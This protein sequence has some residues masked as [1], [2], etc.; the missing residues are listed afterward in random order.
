MPQWS[1]KLGRMTHTAS[2]IRVIERR[3]FRCNGAS[4]RPKPSLDTAHSQNAAKGQTQQR[5]ESI[6]P[7]ASRLNFGAE[8]RT[9]TSTPL[10]VR[11]PEPRA[12]AN[13][14]ISA[15]SKPRYA[16]ATREALVFQSAH[17]L[18]MPG[19]AV[20]LANPFRGTPRLKHQNAALC[21][22]PRI[23]FRVSTT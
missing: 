12:S 16:L 8:K 14:A 4:R 23:P 13:S 11:G 15:H 17:T 20:H 9:R 19:R 3:I 10:R 2:P 5:A 6:R 21:D 1:P 7:F 18:S 22:L